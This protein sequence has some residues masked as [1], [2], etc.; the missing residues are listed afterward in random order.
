MRQRKLFVKSRSD[1][2]TADL[3]NTDRQTVRMI[4]GLLTV[5]CRLNKHT[6]N[7][8]I[9]EDDLCRFWLEEEESTIPYFWGGL[10]P[11][12]QPHGRCTAGPDLRPSF[13]N[14]VW[15]VCREAVLRVHN[16]SVGFAVERSLWPPHFL[17]LFLL[18]PS[19]L[20]VA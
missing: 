6:C 9:T 3:L 12:I 14:P 19:S 11:T 7:L 4:V 20:P 10:S 15:P 18:Y 5:H 8:R 16:R 2:F 13:E 1:R 17:F